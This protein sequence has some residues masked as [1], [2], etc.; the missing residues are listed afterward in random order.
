MTDV[1]PR[2][3]ADRP[4]K[5]QRGYNSTLPA[6][7]GYLPRRTE[8]SKRKTRRASE[9]DRTFKT[10][11]RSAT[12]QRCGKAP[13]VDASHRGSRAQ[14]PD[15]RGDPSNRDDLCRAC[16]EWVEAHPLEATA[17]G[18]RLGETYEAAN[19]EPIAKLIRQAER[20]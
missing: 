13:A 16:H 19:A 2:F 6:P 1:T 3:K 17:E 20:G 5:K 8:M 18:W 15:L 7:V 9:D 4:E 10:G 11:P 12:C 14:R